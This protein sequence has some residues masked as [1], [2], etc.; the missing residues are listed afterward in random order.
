LV[1]WR[2]A[3]TIEVEV[4]ASSDPESDAGPRIW[5]VDADHWPRAYLRAELIEHGYDTTGFETLRD[6]VARLVLAPTLPPA[7]MVVDLRGQ[8]FDERLRAFLF[9]QSIPV[10]VIRG[11]GVAPGSPSLSPRMQVLRRPLTIG[12]IA[13]AVARLAPRAPVTRFSREA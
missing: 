10:I 1:G 5:V 11:A 6:A 12:A 7:A 3:R 13:E 8:R 4:M 9:A 2:A